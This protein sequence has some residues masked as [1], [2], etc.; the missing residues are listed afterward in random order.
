MHVPEGKYIPADNKL[1][2]KGR[3]DSGLFFR[4]QQFSYASWL[5]A[6]AGVCRDNICNRRDIR[7]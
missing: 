4:K 2:H 6:K 1:M 7:R 5:F 3:I